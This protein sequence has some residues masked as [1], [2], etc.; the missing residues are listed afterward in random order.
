MISHLLFHVLVLDGVFA[1]NDEEAAPVFVP[2]NPL[3][4]DDVQ[5]IVETATHRL[6]RFLQ[7]YAYSPTRCIDIPPFSPSAPCFVLHRPAKIG[8]LK[9]CSRRPTGRAH[10]QIA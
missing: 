7:Q 1:C 8:P 6:V 5:R 4:D 3:R 10:D 2:A 9:P